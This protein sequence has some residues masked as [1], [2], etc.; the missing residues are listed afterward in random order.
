M[1][2]NVYAREAWEPYP[3]ERGHVAELRE[4]TGNDEILRSVSTS[5]FEA[6]TAT[7]SE[8]FSLALTQPHSHC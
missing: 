4:S 3:P 2:N 8:L 1:E 5:G 7:E 6:R